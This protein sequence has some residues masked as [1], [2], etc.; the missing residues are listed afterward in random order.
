MQVIMSE[1]RAFKNKHKNIIIEEFVRLETS[2]NNP[3]GGHERWANN[4]HVN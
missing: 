1:K 2:Q 4:F 3:N